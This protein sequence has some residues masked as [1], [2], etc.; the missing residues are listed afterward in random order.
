MDISSSQTKIYCHY[1]KCI[2]DPAN[3]SEIKLN[4]HSVCQIEIDLFIRERSK[5][6]KQLLEFQNILTHLLPE[7]LEILENLDHSGRHITTIH[8]S[9][10]FLRKLREINLSHNSFTSLLDTI[11]N[12]GNLQILYL[13][14]TKI[15]QLPETIGSMN[16]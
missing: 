3:S 1:C 13:S 5:R 10:G 14:N 7:E 16:H 12:L 9:I 6:F 11:C 4:S 2:I 15:S 8:S